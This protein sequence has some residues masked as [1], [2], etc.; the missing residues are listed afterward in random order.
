MLARDR[1]RAIVAVAVLGLAPLVL[2]RIGE[3]AI[4]YLVSMDVHATPGGAITVPHRFGTGP[5]A[6]WRGPGSAPAW[7][8]L[9]DARVNLVSL[10]SVALWSVGVRELDG[11][12]W[13]AWHVVLPAGCLGAAGLLTWVLTP[14]VL[15]ILMR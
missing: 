6:L 9:L 7:L 14:L 13:Q 15:P 10:G 2:D 12:G 1:R 11:H 4:T 3:L 5:A 8:E